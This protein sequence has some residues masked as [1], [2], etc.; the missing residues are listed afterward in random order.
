MS[1][2]NTKQRSLA[3]D[4]QA[5][6]EA[7]KELDGL[8][9]LIDWKE[10]EG[11]LS[12]I[13][14]RRRGEAA[15][16]PLMMFQALLLQSWYGL[17]DPGLEKQLAR[18]LMFKRF[19][20]LSVSSGVPDHSTLWRFRNLLSREGRYEPLLALINDQ[21][22]ERGLII[23]S[24]EISIIDASVIEAKNCRRNKDKEGQD[25]RDPEAG[26]SIKRGANGKQQV[27]YGF[28][29]HLNADEDGFIKS[30][31]MTAGNVHDSQVFEDLLTGKE[32]GVYA[33]SAYK[34]RKRDAELERRGIRNCIMH[35]PWRNQGL[36]AEQKRLNK[37]HAPIRS[38]VERVFGILK[39][40]YGMSK[41]RYLG[42]ARNQAR[43]GMLCMAHNIKRAYG[44]QKACN[45]A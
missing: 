37:R 25:T 20:G 17:S 34:S 44:I 2:K 30:H 45:A 7:I 12:D 3:D 29:A 21:L 19:V 13:H 28:K 15:W 5:E 23:R 4:L 40:H 42:I 18:D 24:G 31:T 16:P 22:S 33:D 6:H 11:L 39:L 1:W 32:T 9:E 35:R 36:T 27:T 43:L 38:T 14:N 26:Y 8:R 10:V 41:A